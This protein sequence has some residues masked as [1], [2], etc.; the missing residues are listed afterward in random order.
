[1]AQKITCPV[2]FTKMNEVGH[3]LVCPE[4]GYKYCE[5]RKPYTYDDHN[6][7]NYQSYNEK[8]SYSTGKTTTTGTYGQG[9]TSASSA[10]TGSSASSYTQ[11]GTTYSQPKT[12]YSQPQSSSYAQKTTYSQ[13]QT[14]SYSQKTTYSRPQTNAAQPRRKFSVGKF[15]F[16]MIFFYIMIFVVAA[17]F[18]LV[19]EVLKNTQ[20]ANIFERFENYFS[21]PN[22]T[23]KSEPKM[24]PTIE[25]VGAEELFQRFQGQEVPD[26]LLQEL[27]VHTSSLPISEVT[28]EDFDRFLDL[29]IYQGEHYLY[30]YYELDDGTE[31]F[32]DS[33]YFDINT[34]ELK[35][36]RC[37]QSFF[38]D[39]NLEIEFQ[40]GDLDGLYDLYCLQ[41]SNSP[42]ELCRIIEPTQLKLLTI[43]ADGAMNLSGIENFTRL[44]YLDVDAVTILNGEEIAQLEDLAYLSVST[45]GLMGFSFLKSMSQL[46]FLE[47]ESNYL[48]DI[49]F[50]ESLPDLQ[51][52]MLYSGTSLFTDIS[53]IAYCKNLN[54]LDLSY[55]TSITDYSPIGTLKD[56]E[57]LHLAYT[58]AKDLSWAKDLTNLSFITVTGSNV[59]DLSPLE[60]LP[61]LETV[62]CTMNNIKNFGTLDQSILYED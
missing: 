58:N 36:F 21:N 39:D 12:T 23:S 45:Q 33:T 5:D 1:M 42:E 48:T 10:Y 55:N 49:S 62:Y 44:Y 50:L 13:P 20:G 40:P 37:L 29:E 27:V 19:P 38:K 43:T 15:V 30:V 9:T 59:T 25:I 2:C 16:I 24:E 4:C 60:N 18:A 54:E 61:Y 11:S 31:D 41:C 47:I 26:S 46:S 57:A 52:L 56:L 51:Y 35:L 6:H 14:S 7:N 3:D 8:T 22:G 17:F 53:P 32:Y 34:S 28:Q